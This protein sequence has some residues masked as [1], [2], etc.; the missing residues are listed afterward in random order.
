MRGLALLAL[1]P[2]VALGVFA[3]AGGG[4]QQQAQSAATCGVER[5]PVKT[6]SD[7]KVGDVNFT[8]HDTSI[9]RLRNKDGPPRSGKT[10]PASMA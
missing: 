5:W 9:G 8:P 4:S 2:V 1:V 10:L 6:L 7:P 3:P